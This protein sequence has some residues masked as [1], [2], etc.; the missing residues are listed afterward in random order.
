[1]DLKVYN[2][3]QTIVSNFY[4]MELRSSELKTRNIEKSI[5]VLV[6]RFEDKAGNTKEMVI[7]LSDL[8]LSDSIKDYERLI[9]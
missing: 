3:L 6:L 1:M 5:I 9:G 8:I 2:K 7:P 4:G